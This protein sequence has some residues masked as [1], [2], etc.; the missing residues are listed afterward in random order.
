MDQFIS[1]LL[2][3]DAEIRQVL[4]TDLREMLFAIRSCVEQH[5]HSSLAAA[6]HK[7]KGTCRFL[8]IQ[9][10]EA[11]IQEFELALEK[12]HIEAFDAYVADLEF[13]K[14]NLLNQLSSN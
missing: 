1:Q 10:I 5:N 2:K 14:D 7:L 6:L 9:T 8:G 11:I 13:E 4:E 3:T 12:N